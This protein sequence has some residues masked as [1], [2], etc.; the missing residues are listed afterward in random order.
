M[1][2]HQCR[3]KVYIIHIQLVLKMSFIPRP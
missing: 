1:M 2:S 3:R